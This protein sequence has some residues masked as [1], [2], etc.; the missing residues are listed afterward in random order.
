MRSL[1]P[2][3]TPVLKIFTLPPSPPPLR[4]SRSL[5]VTLSLCFSPLLLPLFREVVAPLAGSRGATT[6]LKKREQGF[7]FRIFFSTSFA[8]CLSSRAPRPLPPPPPPQKKKP[9][10]GLE[11]MT[12]RCPAVFGRKICKSRTH[13]QL[14]KSGISFFF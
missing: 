8:L 12:L 2:S 3:G 6:S 10:M 7:F 9:D 4:H 5:S 1:A 13:Y 14:C 11:P